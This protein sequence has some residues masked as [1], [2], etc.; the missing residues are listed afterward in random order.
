V[1]EIVAKGARGRNMS[2]IVER[3]CGV[4]G[5]DAARVAVH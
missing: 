4:G 1:V 3:G 2:S 5:K